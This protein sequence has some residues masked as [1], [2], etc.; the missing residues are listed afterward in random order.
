MLHKGTLTQRELERVDQKQ[1]NDSNDSA[2]CLERHLTVFAGSMATDRNVH[3]TAVTSAKYIGETDIFLGK[4]RATY[5]LTN[6]QAP[7]LFIV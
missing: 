5:S 1:L 7:S 3:H 2:V 4:K 6:R